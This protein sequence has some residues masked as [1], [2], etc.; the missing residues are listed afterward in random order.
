MNKQQNKSDKGMTYEQLMS[1][2]LM[3]FPSH[4]KVVHTIF[5]PFL[6]ALVIAIS[7]IGYT[8]IKDGDPG[9]ALIVGVISAYVSFKMYYASSQLTGHGVGIIKKGKFSVLGLPS[10]LVLLYSIALLLL[11][12]MLIISHTAEDGH[13]PS[14]Y[15]RAQVFTLCALF[16][17]VI[18]LLSWR[19]H[20]YHETWYG[21]EHDARL[22][23]QKRGLSKSDIEAKVAL[24]KR[25]GIIA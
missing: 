19:F 21:S 10:I 25:N 20:I 5:H 6:I 23:F 15:A 18:S 12:G 3:K 24:L 2:H 13:F 7:T 22:E 1:S 4:S 17:F 16:S 9:F 11:L 14:F 8:W